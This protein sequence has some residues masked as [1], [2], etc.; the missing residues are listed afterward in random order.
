[1]RRV[2]KPRR[3]AVPCKS[4]ADRATSGR[5]HQVVK[6]SFS[7]ARTAAGPDLVDRLLGRPGWKRGETGRSRYARNASRSDV[8]ALTLRTVAARPDSRLPSEEPP[9]GPG[10]GLPPIAA[11]CGARRTR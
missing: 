5:V 11:C 8:A 10:P 7:G 6:V 9:S 2:L 3:P 4:R 1:M